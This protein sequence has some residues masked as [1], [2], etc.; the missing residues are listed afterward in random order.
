M[1]SGSEQQFAKYLTE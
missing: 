1:T